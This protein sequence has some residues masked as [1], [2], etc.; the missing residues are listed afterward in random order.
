[1]AYYVNPLMTFGRVSYKCAVN[2][3]IVGELRGG[4][5]RV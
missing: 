5:E 2:T 1:M 4:H 3:D